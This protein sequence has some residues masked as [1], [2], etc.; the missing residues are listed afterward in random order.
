MNWKEIAARF[1]A[2][3]GATTAVIGG[4]YLV[5]L[6]HLKKNLR[7]EQKGMVY[8]LGLSE[9]TLRVD[10]TFTNPTSI[11]AS[12][13][14]P[15][16]EVS[17]KGKLVARSVFKEQTE[18]DSNEEKKDYFDLPKNGT[19][20]MQPL[21]LKAKYADILMR[22]PGMI[23]EIKTN[24]KVTLKVQVQTKIDSWYDYDDTQ[25]IV[26]GWKKEDA[27]GVMLRGWK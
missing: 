16:V 9:M 11:G 15:F 23:S 12:I 1:I 18:P 17:F 26:F 7:I 25:D 20:T 13:K 21:E 2:G 6:L 24:G 5:R 8:Q 27:S 19:K 4:G 10:A 22:I 3:V 14:N